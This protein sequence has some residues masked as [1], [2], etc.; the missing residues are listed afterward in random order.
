MHDEYPATEAPIEHRLSAIAE[1][2]GRGVN[3]RFRRPRF[4]VKTPPDNSPKTAPTCLD[5]G[6]DSRL[7][8]TVG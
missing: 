5:A 8:V 2:L 1:L 3:R 6:D 4:A 7:S